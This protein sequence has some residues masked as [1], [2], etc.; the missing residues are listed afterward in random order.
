MEI[1]DEFHMALVPRVTMSLYDQDWSLVGDDK[2]DDYCGFAVLDLHDGAAFIETDS[3]E[4]F[5]NDGHNK[6]GVTSI[7]PK[8]ITRIEN[9]SYPQ[10]SD[11]TKFPTFSRVIPDD[12]RSI[13][14]TWGTPPRRRGG[15]RSTLLQVNPGK[16]IKNSIFMN[17]DNIDRGASGITP[18]HLW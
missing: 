10:T 7:F 6:H 12:P 8:C 11:K 17:I 14:S 15:V 1:N 9:S 13:Y 4:T 3:I 2:N 16:F 18:E 5:E